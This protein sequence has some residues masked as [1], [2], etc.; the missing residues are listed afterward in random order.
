MTQRTKNDPLVE[1]LSDLGFSGYEARAYVALLEG[2]PAT[3]YELA[4]RSGI[5][6][7]KI[8]PVLKKLM[9][10]SMVSPISAD[11]VKYLPQNSKLFL[12]NLRQDFQSALSYIE[13]HLPKQ[14]RRDFDYI[15]NIRQKQELLSKAAELILQARREILLLAWDPELQELIPSLKSRKK[16]VKLAI[17][18]FGEMPVRHPIVYRHRIPGIIRTEKGGREL[19]LVTD[20]ESLLQGLISRS[21]V[22]GI[23]TSNPS[24]VQVALDYMRHEIYTNKIFNRFEKILYRE[25][26]EA[27]KK[28]RNIWK[29]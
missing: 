9:D 28:L 18:Q 5:P 10:R 25:Y 19:T 23:Y 2:H 14:P 21:G 16:T 26:G 24:L 17:I 3:G 29:P 11:P 12:K 7:S 15:W 4:K 13:E 8:Y 6:P 22:N 27:L 20:E 1:H